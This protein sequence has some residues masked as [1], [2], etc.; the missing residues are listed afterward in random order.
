MARELASFVVRGAG[1][2]LPA[3]RL[4]NEDLAAALGTTPESIEARTGIV[5]RR[6]ARNG[7]S[8]SA[9]GA[10]AGRQALEEAGLDPRDVDLLVLSTY[11]PDHLLCPTSPTLAHRLGATGAGTFDVNAACSGGVTSLLA[12]ASLLGTGG[13]RNV[14]V[15]AADLTTRYIREDD[16]KTRLVFGDGAAALLLAPPGSAGDGLLFR[17]RSAFLGSDGSGA[18]HFLV[19]EGG[20]G[21]ARING[22]PLDGVRTVVMN[23]RAIFRFGV[24]Q[25][26]RVVETLLARAGRTAGDVS[27]VV[28]HQANLRIIRA[29][30]ERTGIP[31]DRW[32]TNLQRYGNTA[33]PSVLLALVEMLEQGRVRP[34][35][36]GLLVAFGAGLTWSGL[37][38]EI[39]RT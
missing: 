31:G 4:S 28:P 26:A 36:V 18:E 20:T 30:E 6:V 25:G 10:L 12:G 32:V 2:A 14:L 38:V 16:P 11:T 17:V 34:G 3:G 27:W 13:F 9:L 15:V 33:S 21:P 24:E 22:T 5:E 35:D 37:L 8:A 23:G 39:D 7:E 29:M 1:K 19:P